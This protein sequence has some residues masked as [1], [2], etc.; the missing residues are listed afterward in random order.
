M[1]PNIVLF[2][3]QAD[4]L[5]GKGQWI[6]SL[7]QLAACRDRYI[8]CNTIAYNSCV[9]AYQRRSDWNLATSIVST[10]A[11]SQLQPDKFSYTMLATACA[12]SSFWSVAMQLPGQAAHLRGKVPRSGGNFNDKLVALASYLNLPEHVTSPLC[13]GEVS[14]VRFFDN[15][16]NTG[17]HQAA[18]ASMQAL[19]KASIEADVR[20]ATACVRACSEAE[21]W[22]RA[23]DICSD[24]ASALIEQ[25]S[26][27]CRTLLRGVAAD[28]R[29]SLSMLQDIRQRRYNNQVVTPVLTALELSDRWASILSL[30]GALGNQGASNSFGCNSALRAVGSSTLWKSSIELL[31]AVARSFTRMADITLGSAMGA[32]KHPTNWRVSVSLSEAFPS[33]SVQMHETS[34]SSALKAYAAGDRWEMAS[35]L[36]GDLTAD[37]IRRNTILYGCVLD[38]YLKTDRSIAIRG[39]V[40]AMQEEGIQQSTPSFNALLRQFEDSGSWS[41]ALEACSALSGRMLQ[42]DVVTYSTLVSK[43]AKESVWPQ[44]L[45][46]MSWAEDSGVHLDSIAFNA[47]ASA[48]ERRGFWWIALSVFD[49]LFLARAESTI[50][51]YT[52]ALASW[53]QAGKRQEATDLYELMAKNGV[54]SNAVVLS[55]ITSNFERL[56]EW[57]EALEALTIAQTASIQANTILQNSVASACEIGGKWRIV[58]RLVGSASEPD[59]I[60]CAA[61]MAVCENLGQW[62]QTVKVL[63]NTLQTRLDVGNFGSTAVLRA[64]GQSRRW[65]TSLRT[66]SAMESVDSVARDAACFV[67]EAAGQWR[68]AFSLLQQQK[69]EQLAG[70]I[71]EPAFA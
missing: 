38:S 47:G 31:S 54:R 33:A 41:S 20:H 27:F 3:S 39:L 26:T 68:A 19:H 46:A 69:R 52:A 6:G 8:R 34:Y 32:L 35:M 48:L 29:Y 62:R 11:S 5:Q 15:L 18:T 70:R 12:T 55:T 63:D 10:I 16:A 14:L 37:S 36:L 43:C 67:C 57:T 51:S 71:A 60:G 40:R 2:A 59:A 64:L 42:A 61:A 30:V 28:W 23:L 17:A 56:G 13:S 9:R 65:Q 49:C 24:L 1:E 50:V 21:A 66:L 4:V 53:G 25:D 58:L 44:A 22:S 45:E 7:R